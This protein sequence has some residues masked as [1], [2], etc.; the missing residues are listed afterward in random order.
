MTGL[1]DGLVGVI[2]HLA[3]DQPHLTYLRSVL[4]T[5]R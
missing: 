1:A 3:L 4:I 5:E 2:L